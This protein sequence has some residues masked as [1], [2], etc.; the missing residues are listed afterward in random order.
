MQFP[1]ELDHVKSGEQLTPEAARSF[2]ERVIFPTLARSEQL[3]KERKIVAGGP[4]AGRI[5]L[6][7]ILEAESASDADQI[8]TSLPL[9]P[10]AETRITPLMF[11]RRT[12]AARASSSGEPR[13]SP[14]KP[15]MARAS[16]RSVVRGS[17]LVDHR[18]RRRRPH[19]RRA[20][21]RP[22]GQR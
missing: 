20:S 1:V 3:I 7:V 18:A 12:S 17:G 10:L 11:V 5:A 13:G 15:E 8:V 2:I 14:V 9:W 19:A 16:P 22:R 21:V 4:V 6:R